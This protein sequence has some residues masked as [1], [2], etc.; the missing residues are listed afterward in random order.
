M[1]RLVIGPA[2]GEQAIARIIGLS[3]EEARATLEVWHGAA[4]AEEVLRIGRIQERDV[5]TRRERSFVALA[6]LASVGALSRLPIHVRDALHHGATRGEVRGGA[7][8]GD[9]PRRPWPGRLGPR[10]RPRGAR[11]G[12]AGPSPAGA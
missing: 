4:A 7:A 11:Q 1:D 5:L 10:G 9:G 3:V 8:H 12:G 2:E 6:T